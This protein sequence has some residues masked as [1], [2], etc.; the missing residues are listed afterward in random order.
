[1]FIHLLECCSCGARAAVASTTQLDFLIACAIC[2]TVLLPTLLAIVLFFVW[3]RRGRRKSKA[4]LQAEGSMLQ[5]KQEGNQKKDD[6]QEERRRKAQEAYTRERLNFLRD[7][8]YM[9]LKE[10]RTKAF[11]SAEVQEY[12]KALQELEGKLQS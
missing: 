2:G 4:E 12:L 10:H 11:D 9:N 3:K 8:A 6:N 5:K 7:S 1:M